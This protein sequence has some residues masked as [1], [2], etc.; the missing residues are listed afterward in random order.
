MDGVCIKDVLCGGVVLVVS[1]WVRGPVVV[2][3]GWVV[4]ARAPWHWRLAPIF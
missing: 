2:I 3:L 1:L 4:R